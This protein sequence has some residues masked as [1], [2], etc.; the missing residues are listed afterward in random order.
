MRFLR[1]RFELPVSLL[2]VAAIGTVVWTPQRGEAKEVAKQQTR[3]V[4]EIR[5]ATDGFY[6]VSTKALSALDAG[7]PSDLVVTR[8]GVPVPSILADG[9]LVF[10]A[11]STSGPHSRVAT[12]RIE[13]TSYVDRTAE[14][15]NPVP[16]TGNESRILRRV[17]APDH[18]L[19]AL[20]SADPT[21]YAGNRPVWFAMGLESLGEGSMLLGGMGAARGKEQILRAHVYATHTGPVSLKAAWN[22][23][24]LGVAT[25][26]RASG[27]AVLEWKV[28]AKAIPNMRESIRLRDVT[29]SLPPRARNDMSAGYGSIWIDGF[30]LV[31]PM[32]AVEEQLTY[33]PFARVPVASGDRVP[34]PDKGI[35][36]VLSRGSTYPMPARWRSRD[37]AYLIPDVPS[38][39]VLYAATNATE[40]T[41]TKRTLAPEDQFLVP[42]GTQHVIVAVPELLDAVK[43]LVDHRGKTGTP[44]TVVSIAEIYSRFGYG[45][46]TPEALRAFIVHLMQRKD[47]PLKYVLLVGDAVYDRTDFTKTWTIPTPMARTMYN[48][49][50]ASDRLYTRPVGGVVHTGGP[51]LGRLPFREPK[52]VQAFVDRLIKYENAP[53]KHA[54]RRMMRFITS[55]GRFG[56]IVDTLLESA[57]RKVVADGIPPAYD[58][59]VTFASARSP[60]LW[61]PPEFNAKVIKGVNDGALFYTYVGHGFAEGFDELQAGGRRFPILTVRHAPQIDVKGTKP[62]VLVLACTTAQFDRKQKRGDGIGEALMKRP[63]GPIA[64]WGATRICHPAA[65]TLIA[66]AMTRYL[67]G[68]GGNMRLGDVIRNAIDECI[69]PTK[70]DP[71]LT[72]IRFGIKMMVGG[73]SPD[74]LVR[75]ASEMF[76]LLGD[77]ATKIAF[78]KNNIHVTAARGE[79]PVTL[80]ILAKADLPDDTPVQIS[81]EF[82]RT[83]NAYKPKRVANVLDPEAFPTIRENHKRMND[84]AIARVSGVIKDGK[85]GAKITLST[86]EGWEGLIVKTVAMTTSDVHQGAYVIPAQEED[87]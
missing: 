74:R 62:I 79:E 18:Y 21:V 65:N 13:H 14:E 87:K 75:E 78:P 84:W 38:D 28:P 8:R 46:H 64:F 42:S 2:L 44:S 47:V 77:P 4:G 48:G 19:G 73:V 40:V 67:H 76:I 61:P 55:E 5:V 81:V 25:T 10:L 17:H 30:H 72:A 82:P 52:D 27:G 63:Q 20:A 58:I 31:G 29:K 15:P 32:G 26:Q 1:T 51:A 33:E 6:R 9:E 41:P 16:A 3:N 80:N 7:K 85:V 53:P 39:A 43:P 86:A 60:F 56:P 12:Y 37:G 24:D 69:A 83:A 68:D 54:S 50:T 22:N 71:G 34:A 59:E 36:F 49:A 66:R 35:A 11:L 70:P 23:V 45:E 57:F